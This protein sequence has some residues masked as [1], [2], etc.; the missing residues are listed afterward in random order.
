[1]DDRDETLAEAE[2]G[3]IA[4]EAATA[5]VPE[6]VPLVSLFLKVLA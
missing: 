3:N 1:M 2:L 4:V 5:P 6:H